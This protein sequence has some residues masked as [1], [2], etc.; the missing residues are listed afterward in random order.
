MPLNAAVF[1]VG[2]EQL[3]CFYVLVMGIE[4][5]L[6]CLFRDK[7]LSIFVAGSHEGSRCHGGDGEENRG[8]LHLRSFGR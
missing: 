2:P 7:A 5:T 6:Q 3:D 8:R 4:E 1:Q